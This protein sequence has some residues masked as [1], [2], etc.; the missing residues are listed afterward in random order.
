MPAPPL[1]PLATF[2]LQPTWVNRSGRV[3]RT[4]CVEIRASELWPHAAFRE[5]KRHRKSG[6]TS[7]LEAIAT[8]I[9]AARF[10][11]KLH[12]DRNPLTL[13]GDWRTSKANVM[14]RKALGTRHLA[15]GGKGTRPKTQDSRPFHDERY[16]FDVEGQRRAY[17]RY[18]GAFVR[19][20]PLPA[21]NPN[22]GTPFTGGGKQIGLH[23]DWTQEIVIQRWRLHERLAKHYLVCPTGQTGSRDWGLGNGCDLHLPMGEGRGEGRGMGSSA[24]PQSLLTTASPC[25]S[26]CGKTLK[27]FMPVCSIQESNDSELAEGWVRLVD[28]RHAALGRPMPREVIELRH[29]LLQRYG[30]LFRGRRLVCRK[31]LGVRYGEVKPRK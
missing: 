3:D 25:R 14:K 29:R 8:I 11:H 7:Y 27:L 10:L 19:D 4:A 6:E 5:V 30:L 18:D 31:C 2:E 23:C 12:V 26:C 22:R 17:E 24:N 15:L 20:H 21:G 16:P 28:A 9:L 1:L 13:Q